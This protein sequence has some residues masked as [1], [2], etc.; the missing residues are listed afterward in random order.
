MRNESK[1]RAKYSLHLLIQVVSFF[2]LRGVLLTSMRDKLARTLGSQG[3]K[4]VYFSL[5]LEEGRT[6]LLS[7]A[8]GT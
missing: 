8:E 5:R 2:I 6:E 4:R 7:K 3:G 1:R